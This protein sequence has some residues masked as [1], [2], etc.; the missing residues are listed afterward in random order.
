MSTA[1]GK[2]M[3]EHCQYKVESLNGDTEVLTANIIAEDFLA[4]V[5]EKGHRQMLLD[6]IIDHRILKDII[7]KSEGSFKA[8]FGTIRNKRTTRG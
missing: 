8:N 6:K 3:Y 7:L 2:I 4:Q 1:H 5:D